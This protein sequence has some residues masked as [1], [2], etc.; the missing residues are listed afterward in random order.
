M[1]GTSPAM[2]KKPLYSSFGGIRSGDALKRTSQA[3]I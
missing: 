1:A 3:V 2:T